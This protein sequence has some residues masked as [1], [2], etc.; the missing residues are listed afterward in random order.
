[1]EKVLMSSPLNQ[2]GAVAR[3]PVVSVAL[4]ST[5]TS[6]PQS[7]SKG[8]RGGSLALGVVFAAVAVAMIFIFVRWYFP[9]P[10]TAAPPPP[11]ATAGSAL[12]DVH[13]IAS[14]LPGKVAVVDIGLLSVALG[15]SA[16][17]P[18]GITPQ[19]VAARLR[20]ALR[21]LA[22]S[23]VVVVDPRYVI[24][25]PD[26]VNITPQIAKLVGVDMAQV[27]AAPSSPRNVS[28]PEPLVVEGVGWGAKTDNGGAASAQPVNGAALARPP[29][30]ITNKPGARAIHQE[31]P[32]LD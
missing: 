21:S 12:I 26:S 6:P 9:P 22:D 30:T 28:P 7:P 14:Q 23:G 13:H 19:Q 27:E 5:G 17:S 4:S 3:A 2:N 11:P 1:M 20:T 29:T 8:W 18:E 16:Q 10:D 31:R 15:M 24:A 32:E 25:F